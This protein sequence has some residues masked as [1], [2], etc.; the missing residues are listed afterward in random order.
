MYKL[1]GIIKTEK[2]N[3]WHSAFSEAVFISIKFFYYLT[4]AT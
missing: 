2:D 4:L 3:E 1:S